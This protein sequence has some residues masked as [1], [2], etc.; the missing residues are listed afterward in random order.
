MREWWTWSI[1]IYMRREIPVISLAPPLALPLPPPPP[2]STRIP[3]TSSP[4]PP[5]RRLCTPWAIRRRRLLRDESSD[6]HDNNNPA[7]V[8]TRYNRRRASQPPSRSSVVREIITHPY[9]SLLVRLHLCTPP[10]Y[11]SISRRRHLAYQPKPFFCVPRTPTIYNNIIYREPAGNWYIE[12]FFF[13][14]DMFFRV[15]KI[16]R[17]I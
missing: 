8:Q 3:D 6:D 14:S 4:P 9:L 16:C 5:P 1:Y 12:R 2:Q 10:P 15:S 17:K 7:F 13:S 11:L